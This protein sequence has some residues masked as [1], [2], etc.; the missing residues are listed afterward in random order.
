MDELE[1]DCLPMCNPRSGSYGRV[2]GCGARCCQLERGCVVSENNLKEKLWDQTLRGSYPS[3]GSTLRRCL[4]ITSQMIKYSELKP[5][6]R[7]SNLI[8]SKL[9]RECKFDLLLFFHN[10][11]IH[12]ARFSKYLSYI[13]RAILS[14][15]MQSY[16]DVWAR[17][18]TSLCLAFISR[19]TCSQAA[20]QCV[21]CFFSVW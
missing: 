13:S 6:K 19:P 2:R 3:S 18:P 4:P 12:S 20:I 17:R 10:Y 8:C 5:R 16:D 1:G 15:P 21:Y 7:S 9:L 14:F 11:L